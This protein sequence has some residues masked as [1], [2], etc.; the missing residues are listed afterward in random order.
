MHPI[1][2]SLLTVT[3]WDCGTLNFRSPNVLNS[4]IALISPDI[5]CHLLVKLT[6]LGHHSTCKAPKK[7]SHIL[8]V[9]ASL[10]ALIFEVWPFIFLGGIWLALDDG[11]LYRK[12]YWMT[13]NMDKIQR[14]SWKEQFRDSPTTESR[15]N[16]ING[17]KNRLINKSWENSLTI[18]KQT[19]GIWQARITACRRAGNF[20]L[21]WTHLV[22]ERSES[23][24]P[25]G[26]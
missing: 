22:C 2:R 17:N 16:L 10:H 25:L 13:E 21:L 11:E 9:H 12:C 24:V 23:A 19:G 8:S 3:I 7:C 1:V 4:L 20:S 5:A 26:Y 18:N 6:R 14:P 15:K